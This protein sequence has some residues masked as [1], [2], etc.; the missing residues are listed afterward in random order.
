MTPGYYIDI[1]D[2]LVIVY[3]D[4]SYE[5]YNIHEEGFVLGRCDL[6]NGSGRF[7]FEFLGDL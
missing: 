3:P 4:G 7:L 5:V 2:D 1:L 6:I